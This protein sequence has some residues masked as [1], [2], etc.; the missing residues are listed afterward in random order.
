MNYLEIYNDQ[1]I[2]NQFYEIDKSNRV[3][4]N[5]GLKHALNV[6]SNIEK[7]SKILNISNEELKY[8][9]IAGYLHDIGRSI[10][11]E[12]RDHD[13]KG[14]EF[15]NDYLTNK[16]DK[17]WLGKISSAVEKHHTYDNLETLSLFEHII[18][19][20]DK[21]DFSTA[22]VEE[23]ETKEYF[24]KNIQS[25][26]FKIDENYIYVIIQLINYKTKEDFMNWDPSNKIIKR[27]KE[28]ADKLDRKYKINFI[29]K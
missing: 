10:T 3:Y 16:I 1:Y 14:A 6:V 26:D 28:F 23:N 7:L 13:I 24:E 8:L 29:I 5:H 11:K 15:I 19:F 20:A 12:T 25:I 4:K 2:R 27:I 18:L 9:K 21:M 17:N 22:R